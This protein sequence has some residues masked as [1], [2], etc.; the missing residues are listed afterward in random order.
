MHWK[1]FQGLGSISG[2][3]DFLS[4]EEEV[5]YQGTL[6][7]EE[8]EDEGPFAFRRKKDCSYHAVS[9]EQILL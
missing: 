3:L 8:E 6:S 5:T 2:D 4:S 7:E 1:I 9:F